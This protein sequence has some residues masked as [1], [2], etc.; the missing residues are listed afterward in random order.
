MADSDTVIQQR[1]DTAPQEVE[2]VDIYDYVV[3]NE[4]FEDSV[5]AIV[6]IIEAEKRTLERQ[7]PFVEQ[8][9]T[10]LEQWQEEQR[11]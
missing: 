6:N 1:L 8:Y 4:N 11:T 7:R 5:E 10:E 3:V 9:R 2:N